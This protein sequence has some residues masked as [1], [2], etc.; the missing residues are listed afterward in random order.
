MGYNRV[1]DT[2]GAG[3]QGA[4]APPLFCVAKRKRQ[5]KKKRK[6]FKAG[7]IKRLSPRS[8]SQCY[9]FSH[10]TVSRIQNLFLLAS[11]GGQQ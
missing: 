8:M 6:S 10:S 2:G 3:L 7:T 11:H 5:K 9:C 1:D 4:M